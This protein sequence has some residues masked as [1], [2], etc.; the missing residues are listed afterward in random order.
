MR[1]LGPY[2]E[3]VR[4][5]IVASEAHSQAHS[6]SSEYGGEEQPTYVMGYNCR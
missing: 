4:L 2:S 5:R 1:I 3:G 6:R